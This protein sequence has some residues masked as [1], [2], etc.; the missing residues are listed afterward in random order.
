MAGVHPRAYRTPP[1][2]LPVPRRRYPEKASAGRRLGTD[3]QPILISRR[4]GPGWA[5]DRDPRHVG[6]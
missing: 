2:V 1:Q 3:R 4:T 5:G 6:V